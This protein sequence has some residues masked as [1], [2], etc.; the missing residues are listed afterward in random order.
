MFVFFHSLLIFLFFSF[1]FFFLIWAV[2]EF[3][4]AMMR[5]FGNTLMY[6]NHHIYQAMPKMLSL[7]LDYGASCYNMERRERASKALSQKLAVI[8][9]H[10]AKMN[11]VKLNFFF[12]LSPL[13]KL[14]CL[15]KFSFLIFILFVAEWRPAA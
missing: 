7:W 5:Y 9:A 1:L 10:L 13:L 2:S 6:G 4:T 14:I 3:A 11:K 15:G 12:S 8:R